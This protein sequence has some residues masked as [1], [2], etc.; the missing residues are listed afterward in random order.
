MKDFYKRTKYIGQRVK[1]LMG[2]NQ[3]RKTKPQDPENYI[4]NTNNKK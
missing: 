2:S 4:F 3:K 1:T